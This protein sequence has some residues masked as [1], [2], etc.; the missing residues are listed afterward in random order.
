MTQIPRTRTR[1]TDVDCDGIPD[2]LHEEMTSF[3]KTTASVELNGLSAK[4][5]LSPAPSGVGRFASDYR[6]YAFTATDPKVRFYAGAET[7][8]LMSFVVGQKV[9]R[10]DPQGR[11]HPMQISGFAV[12]VPTSDRQKVITRGAYEVQDGKVVQQTTLENLVWLVGAQNDRLDLHRLAP[13]AKTEDLSAPEQLLRPLFDRIQKYAAAHPRPNDLKDPAKTIPWLQD[14][15]RFVK[16][17]TTDWAIG[18]KADDA[19]R[20]TAIMQDP[21]IWEGL[22][23][24]LCKLCGMKPAE[25]N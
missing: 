3:T 23:I 18:A 10:V 13:V 1:F 12:A 19:K 8:H 7:P 5:Q 16:G 15:L 17:A 6:I 14:T 4:Y 22:K 2:Y 20:A 24:A 25:L 21:V 9:G 11:L